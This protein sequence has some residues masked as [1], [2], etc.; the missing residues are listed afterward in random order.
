MA[1]EG[2]IV[3][4]D[5]EPRGTL[6]RAHRL[7]EDLASSFARQVEYYFSDDNLTKDQFL[8]YGSCCFLLFSV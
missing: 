1:E 3:D 2:E 8:R 4:S 6:K 7:P 5:E